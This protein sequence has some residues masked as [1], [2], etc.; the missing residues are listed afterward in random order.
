MKN[1]KSAYIMF[2]QHKQASGHLHAGQELLETDGAAVPGL[3]GGGVHEAHWAGAP[4]CGG[5]A[6]P[7]VEY[8]ELSE[9]N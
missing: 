8:S 9:E 4:H 3:R 2:N 7:K 1:A 6:E 5:D